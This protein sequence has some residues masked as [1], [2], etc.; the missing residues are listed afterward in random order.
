MIHLTTCETCQLNLVLLL[1]ADSFV[2]LVRLWL[3]FVLVVVL[4]N[5]VGA[6][7]ALASF[8]TCVISLRFILNIQ[9]SYQIFN[10]YILSLM[11]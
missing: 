1:E 11:F 8:R 9:R 2:G 6:G 4:L 3:P 10:L 7:V 5:H